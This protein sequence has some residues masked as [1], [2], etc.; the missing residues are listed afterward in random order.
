MV[1]SKTP[2][3][4]PPPRNRHN[5][6]SSLPPE[7]RLTIVDLLVASADSA[8]HEKAALASVCSE[9]R[10]VVEK[11]TFQ[12]LLLLEGDGHQDVRAFHRIVHG[13]RRRLVKNLALH[14]MLGFY[15]CEGCYREESG[16]EVDAN[17]WRF[18][19]A[20]RSLWSCLSRWPVA[21]DAAMTLEIKCGA[22]SD[23]QHFFRDA[24]D[25]GRHLLY[26]QS[27]QG[28]RFSLWGARKRLLGTLLDF[29]Q[30]C[31]A[32][33]LLPTVRVVRRLRVNKSLYRSLSAAALRVL[34]ESLVDL[35]VVCYQPW[36]GV[37]VQ[38]QR[39]RD[40]ANTALFRTLGP[41]ACGVH[42]WEAQSPE[43]HGD[44][45][46]PKP[47]N[48]KLVDAVV[49][50]SYRLRDVTIYHAIDGADFFRLA[51]ARPTHPMPA[52]PNLRFLV[53]SCRHLALSSA[54]SEA[55]D[56]LLTA[57]RAAMRMPRLGCMELWWG[58]VNGGYIFRYRVDQDATTVTV[59]ATSEAAPHPDVLKAWRRVAYENTR[60]QL[61]RRAVVLKAD[62]MV[63]STAICRFL[64]LFLW[65]RELLQGDAREP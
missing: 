7:L 12:S 58:E 50:A 15:G 33:P 25:G 62:A 1:E 8:R 65:L 39:A 60:H 47:P 17:N 27:L 30:D 4:K 57:A 54:Q 16:E 24:K 52:W 21:G 45:Y 9:W 22:L 23:K 51:S 42:L 38:G 64:W 31:G 53:L 35:T 55:Y 44:K 61:Q 14:I 32:P 48:A 34:F 18:T 10:A 43:L 26:D 28:R 6:F 36:R 49:E 40:D 20:V 63:S 3:E 5:S 37:D 59:V 41:S 13:Q 46:R 29:V 19:R 11:S 2:P 56:L